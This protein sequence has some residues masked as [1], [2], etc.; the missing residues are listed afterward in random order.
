MIKILAVNCFSLCICSNI[1]A[2]ETASEDLNRVVDPRYG[3]ILFEYYQGNYQ[4]AL[5]LQA[6]A[7]YKSPLA[8]Q[9][10]APELLKGGMSLKYGLLSQ[11]H[12]IFKTLLNSAEDQTILSAAWFYTGKMHYQA[13]DF[14]SAA[15]ALSQVTDALALKFSDEFHYMKAQLAIKNNDEIGYKNEK[16]QISAQHDYHE[17]IEHNALLK[18]LVLNDAVDTNI[19]KI[20]QQNT[21]L[22]QKKKLTAEMLALQN[23]SY[24]ALGFAFIKQGDNQNAIKTFKHISM[25]SHLIEPALLGYGWALNNMHEYDKARNV[26]AQLTSSEILTPYVQEALLVQTYSYQ[27]QGDLQAA[28]HK[29]IIS[30]NRFEEYKAELSQKLV[31]LNKLSWRQIYDDIREFESSK[32]NALGLNEILS[33]QGFQSNLAQLELL[34]ALKQ[35]LKTQLQQI[36]SFKAL[37]DDKAMNTQIRLHALKKKT[38]QT[39]VDYLLEKRNGL[40]SKVNNAIKKQDAE[41]FFTPS[42]LSLKKRLDSTKVV[43]A[44]LPE[45]KFVDFESRVSRVQGRLIWQAHQDFSARSWQ[46]KKDIKHL[47]NFMAQLQKQKSQLFKSIDTAQDMSDELSRIKKIQLRVDTHFNKNNHIIN[48]LE[49]KLKKAF[50]TY[51]AQ[52]KTDLEQAIVQ[53]QLLNI[54]MQDQSFSKTISPEHELDKQSSSSETL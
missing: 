20:T 29:L 6:I 52:R 22:M 37:L 26:L 46:A 41:A 54:Q 50:I 49:T 43:L 10:V 42:Q 11:A 16:S 36:G 31:T 13:E 23:R 14:K 53:A 7:E 27:Q 28:Q 5:T 32:N 2:T 38:L 3:T 45:G 47:D 17:Y 21:N 15:A 12:D 30:I 33:G 1:F 40:M 51:Y 4:A 19:E 35:Q 9:G 34:Y 48:R 44:Q 39:Q 18:Q 25:K 24:L 8:H